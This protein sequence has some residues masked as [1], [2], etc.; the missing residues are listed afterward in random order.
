MGVPWSA[1]RFDSMSARVEPVAYQ[2]YF[3]PRSS[4]GMVLAWV[5]VAAN[6]RLVLGEIWQK[7]GVTCSAPPFRLRQAQRSRDG[8]MTRGDGCSAPT[9]RSGTATG[10]SLD[11]HG[12]AFEA[13]SALPVD[14]SKF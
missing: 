4:G 9:P 5:S 13:Y 7:R 10:R 1:A 2:A 8:W 3:A 6:D 14:S 11:G 12:A